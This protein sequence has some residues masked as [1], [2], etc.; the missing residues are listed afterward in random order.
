MLK[1]LRDYFDFNRAE[2]NSIVLLGL[3]LILLFLVPAFLKQRQKPVKQDIAA[4]Q[5]EIA[6]FE[7]SL[8]S[9]RDSSAGSFEQKIDF[10]RVDRSVVEQELTP[11]PFNPNEMT[12]AMWKKLGLKEWQVRILVN[13]TSKGGKFY[14]KDDF[15]K[16][17]GISKAQYDVLAPFITIPEKE[18][19]VSTKD[20]KEYPAKAKA[21]V[22]VDLNNADSATLVTLNGIGPSFAKR[23]IKFRKLLGGFYSTSQLLEVYG[24]DS[25]RYEQVSRYCIVNP[26]DVVKINLNSTSSEAL[27]KHPYFD[28]YLAKAIVDRRII[29]GRYTSVDEVSQLPLVHAALF[30]KIRYY[31]TIE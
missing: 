4:F 9:K 19:F 20:R 14:K 15:Q 25:V 27:R 13:Y 11:F 21:I 30:N 16:I 2:R 12:A 3:L 18:S 10:E 26:A 1:H 17:Y 5:A 22:L 7:R 23:I 28:H 24:F 31:L 6:A 29:K 8:K